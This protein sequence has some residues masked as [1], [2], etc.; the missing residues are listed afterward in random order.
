MDKLQPSNA[1]ERRPLL[2]K[3]IQV[4]DPVQAKLTN[5]SQSTKCTYKEVSEEPSIEI[6]LIQR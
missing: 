4:V 6:Q 5:S 1:H 2:K 3:G